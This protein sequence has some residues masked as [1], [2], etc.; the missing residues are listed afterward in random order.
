MDRPDGTK[1]NH[2]CDN[3]GTK[4]GLHWYGRTSRIHCGKNACLK[5]LDD[6]YAEMCREMEA[7]AERKAEWGED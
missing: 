6:E 4:E 3:C 2:H 7:E 1:H 5:H